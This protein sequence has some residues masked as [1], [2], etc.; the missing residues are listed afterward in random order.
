[1]KS[2]VT[3]IVSG[4]L[5]SVLISATVWAQGTA[6]ISGTVKDQSGA[7]LPGVEV[8][9]TQTDT[10]I[11]R[12]A[13]TNETGSY[14]LPNLAVGPYKVDAALSGF[15]TYVQSGIVLQV[16]SNPVINPVLEVGQ[17]SEQVEVQANAAMVETRNAGV[18]QVIENQRI[19]ELPLNGRQVTELI[20]LAG[21]AVQTGSTRNNNSGNVGGSPFISVG[22]GLGFGVAYVLDGA[23]HLN[24]IN[25]TA[26]PLPF[27]DALQE[28]KVETSGLGAQYGKETAVNSVTKSG[29]NELHG[30]LFEFLR[31]DLFNAR[32]YFAAKG[33]TLKR[34]QF[35]GTFGGPVKQN[36]LFF[37]AGYQGTTIR[38]DPANLEAFLPTASVLAG[39]WNAFTSPAC[40]AGRSIALRGAFVNNRIDPATYSRPALNIVSRLNQIGPEPCGKVTFGRRNVTDENQFVGK[41]DYQ[42]SAKQSL[43]GRYVATTL[44]LA[45]PAQ[46]SPGNLLTTTVTGQD[47][48]AQ[49]FTLGDTYLFSGN[50]VNSFRLSFNRVHAVVLGPE[51]FSACD[52]GVRMYCGGFEKSISLNVTGGFVLGARFIPRNGNNYDHWTGTSYQ[53]GDDLSLISGNHQFALGGNVMQGR[54]VEK[55]LWFAIGL[56]SFT[57]QATNLGLADFMTGQ[58][59]QLTT[60]G[61]VHHSVNHNQVALYGSDTWKVVPRLTMN[62]GLRWEPYLPQVMTNGRAYNFD[63]ARFQQGIKSTVFKNAPAGFTYIGDPGFPGKSGINKRWGQ[64]APRIGLAWDVNGDGRTSIR[65][66]YAYGYDFVGAL[67][68]EDYSSAAPWTNNTTIT[69]VPFDDPWRGFPGGNPFPVSLGADAR[70]SPYTMFQAV[71]QN[72]RTPSTSSWNLSVQRQIA[73]DWLVSANYIGTQATHIWS[74]QALNPAIYFPGGPCTIRGITYNPCSSTANTNERRRLS[75]E[76]PLD[77]QFIGPLSIVDDGGTQSYH[78]LLLNVQRR[79][80]RG[81][82]VGTNYTFSHC[83]GDYADLTTQGPDAN[84]TYTVPTNRDA[85]R[86]NCNTD[87]RHILNMTAVAESPTFGG[88]TLRAVV[89]GWRLSGIYRWSSGAPMTVITGTDRA[90][91]GIVFQRAD[92]VLGNPYGDKSGRPLTNW[93]NPAAFLPPAIGAIGNVGRNSVV[94]P[95]VWS[96]DLALS[97]TFRVSEN[98]RLEARAEAYNI[99]NSFR[100]TF[101]VSGSGQ[102]QFNQTLATNTFGQI[103]QSLD[104]RILQFALKYVF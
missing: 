24:F 100:P 93:L 63:Y 86:G 81:V 76:R 38:E 56:M 22:G 77:G 16:G 7:V 11:A 41:V 82:T 64:F 2:V 20:T 44:N 5:V 28:F 31:N 75:L 53:I 66:S 32:N 9:A 79:A 46:F 37:F 15:R 84:E 70:F 3:L 13:V 65:A 97:R 101:P 27:P 94:A 95:A 4:L 49:S 78:G 45:V 29:T 48:L 57:G 103:R 88:P 98:N 10:G 72:M 62:Y 8:T 83:I 33:S 23:N 47:N 51:V 54:H 19:L 14:V 104:P 30:S 102:G 59:S 89:S 43:F 73:A 60:A 50:T 68:R 17:V 71:P 39:D 80:A 26:M 52:A 69:G 35:G 34:N 42:W 6:Q 96:F 67:W 25:A 90:L 91:N 21:A 85:D 55:Y 12:S 40:N 92:Q 36:K 99:T 18:G 74:Q 1:M 61:V 87:R 58:L